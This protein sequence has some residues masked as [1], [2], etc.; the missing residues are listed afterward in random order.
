MLPPFKS[1]YF[2]HLY[3]N[4]PKPSPHLSFLLISPAGSHPLFLPSLPDH[5]DCRPCV[6]QLFPCCGSSLC[7][8]VSAWLR[9][10]QPPPQPIQPCSFLPCSVLPHILFLFLL[11]PSKNWRGMAFV[12][13]AGVPVGWKGAQRLWLP[14]AG[15]EGYSAWDPPPVAGPDPHELA[16]HSWAIEPLW[17]NAIT[18]CVAR[19]TQG[20]WQRCD[21]ACSSWVIHA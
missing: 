21:A 5:P 9:S 20:T 16:S 15:E 2:Q 19:Y 1:F 17:L 12:S 6:L 7:Y 13:S 10:R 8:F 11:M 3:P 18:L 4:P 14:T